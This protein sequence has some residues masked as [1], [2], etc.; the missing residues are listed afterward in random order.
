MNDVP[1]INI[2]GLRKI[3]ARKTGTNTPASLILGRSFGKGEVG[4]N[5]L[6]V[7]RTHE[8]NFTCQIVPKYPQQIQ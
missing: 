7:S 5:A 3:D 4:D 1:L 2:Y 8:L 6:H